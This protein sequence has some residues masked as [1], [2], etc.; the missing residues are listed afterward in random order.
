MIIIHVLEPFASGVS[1]AVSSIAS[2]L[3]EFT[4]IVVHGSRNWT[5]STEKVKQRFPKEVSFVEWKNAGREINLLRDWKAFLELISILKTFTDRKNKNQDKIVVHLHSSKAG[6]LGRLACRI[7]GIKAVIYTPHCGAFIRTDIDK[8]KRKFYRFFEWLGGHFGGRV[9]GC[10]PSEGEFYKKLGKD[11]TF[12]SNGVRVK[13]TANNTC[14]AVSNKN[15]DLHSSRNLISFSGVL[16]FQKDPDFWNEVACAFAESA[17]KKGFSFCWIGDGPEFKKLNQDFI[18]VTGWKSAAEVED[19]L[20]RTAVYF[21]SSL[22]EGLPYGVLEAMSSG[23]A[24]LLR[25]VPGNKDLVIHNENG[26]L[27]NT[28]E[29]AIEM[30]DTMLSD[31]LLLVSMGKRSQEI[32][33]KDF[34]LEKMGESY[35]KIY[36][37]AIMET[38]W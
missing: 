26:L 35:K 9:V 23:C 4:H 22:W 34:S 16:S 8:I 20:E 6:F 14:Y 21:S 5:E 33:E 36:E 12:V 10:G 38:K 31:S 2:E 7:L 15:A 37:S 27:F 13:K 17:G 24:L 1:T 18:D 19:F 28:K 25:N 30:L 32:I 3:P 29:E 11:T